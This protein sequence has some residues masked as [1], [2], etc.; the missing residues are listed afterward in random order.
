MQTL[1]SVA[2][3][4]RVFGCAPKVEAEHPDHGVLQYAVE[5]E[6]EDDRISLSVLPVAE[7][8]NV[9]VFTKRPP[10]IVRLNLENVSAV[11]VVNTEEDGENDEKIEILFHNQEVQTLT[12][13][14]RPVVVLLWGNQ[15]YSPERHPPW[16][17]D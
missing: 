1:P 3:L 16:E 14:L 10:R 6:S 17:R 11:Q 8:V 5:F 9:S 12:L 2:E 7:E 4:A 15:Q 13:R